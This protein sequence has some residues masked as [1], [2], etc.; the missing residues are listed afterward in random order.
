MN[1]NLYQE[2]LFQQKL[3]RDLIPYKYS[4]SVPEVYD[5]GVFK[6]T[7]S[8]YFLMEPFTPTLVSRWLVKRIKKESIEFFT[9]F[10]LQLALILEVF[11]E[12]LKID[13]RDLKLNNM[14]IKEEPIELDVKWSK[15]EYKIKFPFQIVIIDFGFA[16]KGN[17]ID[18][19]NDFIKPKFC[20]KE[21]RDMFQAL[22]HIWSIE[23]LR[24]FLINISLGDWIK[25]CIESSK[26]PIRMEVIESIAKLNFLYS[27]T[28]D[29]NFKAPL[30]APRRVIEDCMKIIYG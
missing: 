29:D 13:H 22:V 6:Q 1:I 16:C 23:T 28:D 8:I 12:F 5:I 18:L 25:G 15:G 20:P 10:I 3:Y 27:V 7:N 30:C 9:Y 4:F 21:G 19:K 14:L 2:A 11:E 26:Q 24:I 17:V